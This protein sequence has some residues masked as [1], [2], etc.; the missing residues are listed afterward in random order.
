[1][2]KRFRSVAG[3]LGDLMIPRPTDASGPKV[4]ILATFHQNPSPPV[5][6]PYSGAPQPRFGLFSLLGYS[7][8]EALYDGF[9]REKSESDVMNAL[10]FSVVS[11]TSML[12]LRPVHYHLLEFNVEY[13]CLVFYRPFPSLQ[14]VACSISMLIFSI[15]SDPRFSA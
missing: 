11:F 10:P 6:K 5:T 8:R 9:R 7:Y 12:R 14:F 13:V 4:T 2:T 1:M 3:C 15:L